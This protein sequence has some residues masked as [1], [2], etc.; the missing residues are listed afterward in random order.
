MTGRI[1]YQGRLIDQA[2]Q[3]EY[4]QT[5]TPLADL[6]NIVCPNARVSTGAV[7]TDIAQF[8]Q[9]REVRIRGDPMLY[10]A[11]KILQ[12]SIGGQTV[13][14]LPP[15]V[16]AYLSMVEVKKPGIFGKTE[17]YGEAILS[18]DDVLGHKENA[19]QG[20]QFQAPCPL[21]TEQDSEQ[22]SS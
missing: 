15:C 4:L 22:G 5:G 7:V 12:T 19:E 10:C 8:S 21:Y 14:V 6:V 16:Q 13:S 11:H 2:I 3:M 20:I 17:E 9:A 18:R 1:P